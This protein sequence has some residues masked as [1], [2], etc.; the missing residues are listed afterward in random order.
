LIFGNNTRNCYVN[1]REVPG[2]DELCATLISH[3]GD[4]NGPVALIDPRK[5]RFNPGAITNITP[6]SKPY[7]NMNWAHQQCFRDPVPV[8]RDY[9]LVSHAPQK[10]F[11][12]Y[13]IDRWGNRELLYNDPAISSMCPSPLR[14]APVPPELASQVPPE[15]AAGDGEFFVVDV[16]A[17]LGPAV[18]RGSVRYLRVSQEVRADLEQLPG[19]EYR[20]DH[21]PFQSFYAS[22]TDLVRGPNGW[23]TYV[24]KAALGMVP[25]E[26]DG[27]VRFQAPAGKVLYFQLLDGDLNEVQR[28]RSVVQLQPGEKRSCIGCHEQRESASP[29]HATLAMQHPPRRLEPPS[30]GA[31]PFAYEKVVQPVWDKHC[32]I[33]HDQKDAHKLDLSGT[34][35]GDR[36]PASYRTLITGGWVHYFDM[37]WSLPHDK[38]EPLTF[39]TVKSRLLKVIEPGHQGVKLTRDEM[40]RVKCWIDLNCPLWPDYTQRELRPALARRTATNP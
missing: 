34:T 20:K 6:D 3:G 30:W 22:P 12:I 5:G 9:F 19:G 27:S 15:Q 4:L 36:V 31:V 17:G 26:T 28:M 7:Y 24:V 11:G 16:Y 2:T 32:V 38:A 10:L 1:A 18:A 8:A 33:C 37:K 13:I 14:P 39:G 35:G 21:P 40:H 23:P 25:V 29:V